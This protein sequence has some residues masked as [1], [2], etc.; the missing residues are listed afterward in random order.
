MF[1]PLVSLRAATV[2]TRR[3]FNPSSP[4]NALVSARRVPSD[5]VL[6]SNI[7]CVL[8]P[9]PF[10]TSAQDYR[11]APHGVLSS[12]RMASRA[13]FNGRGVQPEAPNTAEVRV[14]ADTAEMPI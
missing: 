14:L 9:L 3:F 13:P 5:G 2:W 7:R 12:R 10:E 4:L 6:S 8:V 11:E 1:V